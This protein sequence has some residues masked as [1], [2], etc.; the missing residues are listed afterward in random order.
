MHWVVVLVGIMLVGFPH[1]GNARGWQ[2][3]RR[4]DANGCVMVGEVNAAGIEPLLFIFKNGDWSL[5]LNSLNGSLNVGATAAVQ[6]YVD[7]K[8][9]GS[10]RGKNISKALTKIP[11]GDQGAFRRA[12]QTGRSLEIVAPGGRFTFALRGAGSA[13]NELVTCFDRIRRTAG[14]PECRQIAHSEASAMLA[15]VLDVAG[16]SDYRAEPPTP[17]E[18]VAIGKFADGTSLVL[19]ACQGATADAADLSAEQGLKSAARQCRGELNIGRQT[20]PSS[21]G[22]II[23]KVTTTCRTDPGTIFKEEVHIRRPDRLLISFGQ[24]ASSVAMPADDARRAGLI[25]ALVKVARQKLPADPPRTMGSVM[26]EIH[27]DTRTEQTFRRCL[28]VYGY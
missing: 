8:Y 15:A 5:A 24:I 23:R 13:M 4:Q 20:I 6:I 17:G 16:V 28:R 14:E 26:Q 9:V 11:I 1:E 25:D 18:Q 27:K 10:A 7:G 21:D 22:S 3:D 19:G 12:A 2:V